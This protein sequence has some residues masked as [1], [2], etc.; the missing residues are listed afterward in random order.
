MFSK[1]Y[2]INDNTIPHSVYSVRGAEECAIEIGSLSKSSGFTGLRC[3]W[4]VLPKALAVGGSPLTPHWRRWLS[5]HCNGVGYPIQR[6]AE[7]ALSPTG[8]RQGAAALA[9]YRRN[10][11]RLIQYF[12]EKDIPYLGGKHAPYLWVK[13]PED[14]N[15]WDTFHWLLNECGILVTPGAGF[16]EAGEGWLRLTAFAE[17]WAV[18]EA[19]RRFQRIF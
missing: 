12:D 9:T 1:H 15:S 17:E 2:Y 18:S 8:K 14:S 19:I 3:G 5:C 16:G 10:A 4:I 13:C 11:E 6:A 7:A